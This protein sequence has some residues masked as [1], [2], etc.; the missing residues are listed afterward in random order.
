MNKVLLIT[1]TC[2]DSVKGI[3]V[4]KKNVAQV[5]ALKEAGL[6]AFFGYFESGNE[7]VIKND[8]T[9]V[10]RIKLEGRLVWK[11]NSEL[12]KKIYMFVC[13]NGINTIYSRFESYSLDS[14]FFYRTLKKCGCKVLMEVPTYPVTPQRWSGV[15]NE[16]RLKKY[17]KF[18][19]RLISMAND[20][21]GIPFFKIVLDRI[22]TNTH[23]D[24]IWGT[25]T[26]QIQNGVDTN[27]IKIRSMD[28]RNKNL[29]YLLGVA[30]VATWHGYD[31]II[32]GIKNYIKDGK[33][34]IRIEF[35]IAGAGDDLDYLKNLAQ[36]L[37][38]N[39]YVFFEGTKSGNELDRI[40]DI[41]DV[42]IGVLGIH[43]C[44]MSHC[45]SLKS[46]EY[47]SR[48]IPFV[49][50]E[51][52]PEFIDLEYVMKVPSNDEPVEIKDIISFANHYSFNSETVLQ[53]RERSV[54]E[55][56]WSQTFSNVVSYI[57][58]V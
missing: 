30:N 2:A 5:K 51:C 41:A 17:G 54:K 26:I 21:M 32:R 58:G 50:T 33:N 1:S 10:L 57:K 48:G 47:C 39:E 42:G 15:K 55:Y 19:R 7:F 27:S 36:E 6:I 31:R 3:G 13:E 23:L 22:V 14:V 8:S 34:K 16:L 20:S 24:E 43:R 44:S 28:N 38:V 56:D 18:L 45:D 53:M 49:T 9:I 52:E 40:F 4:Y 37:D 12:S 35:H 11:R 29:I 46:K 25:K